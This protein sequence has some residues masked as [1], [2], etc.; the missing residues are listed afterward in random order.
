M[1]MNAKAKESIIMPTTTIETLSD[2][3][4]ICED[5]REFY[6]TA[7]F[8]TNSR[9]LGETFRRIAS[10]RESVIINLRL[11]ALST[12]GEAAEEKIGNGR[13]SDIF[14][15]LKTEIDDMELTLVEKLER[16]ENV[17]LEQFREALK[18]EPPEATTNLIERQMQLLHETYFHIKFLKRHLGSAA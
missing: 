17:A 8:R 3:I 13:A 2:L 16:A 9:S 18:S 4:N 12:V 11:H 14:G 6:A 15:P 1:R 10:T 7:A 5:A